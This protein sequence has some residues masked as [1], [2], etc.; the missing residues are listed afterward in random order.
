MV[1]C[2]QAVE[3]AFLLFKHCIA[4]T[5]SL[6]LK[7]LLFAQID[8]HPLS[9]LESLAVSTQGKMMKQKCLR[10][11]RQVGHALLLMFALSVLHQ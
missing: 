9:S 5:E 1:P 6:V 7:R 2:W 3:H 4:C 8:C 10:R 11:H